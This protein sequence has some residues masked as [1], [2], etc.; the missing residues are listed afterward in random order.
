MSNEIMI[1]ESEMMLAEIQNSQSMCQLLMQSPHY[2]K[3]GAEGVFAIVEKAKSVGISPMDAL[4]GGCYYVQGKVE[5][6]SAMMNQLIRQNGH[7]ISRDKRSDDTICILHGRRADNGDI[8]SE[9]FSIG[10]AK[11]AG[12]YRNQWLKYPKDML[13]A[14]AL[15]RLARQLFPDVIK[16][17]YVQG[18]IPD[19]VPANHPYIEP[20]EVVV[21]VK[22]IS[23]DELK[24]IEVYLENNAA[25]RSNISIFMEKKYGISEIALM[26]K[27]FYP[28]AL[29][30]AKKQFEEE[31]QKEA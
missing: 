31:Q 26:P 7:S 15:T 17:C 3:M 18:E 16:G 5:L 4:N 21:D 30:R 19:E 14:R 11:L 28:M 22:K 6:S 12:I 23:E 29:D 13:F 1:K 24:E 10:D 27:E 9:S 25:L 2:K 20:A 8:W